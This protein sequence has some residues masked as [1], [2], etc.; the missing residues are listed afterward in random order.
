MILNSSL[1]LDILLFFQ[2]MSSSFFS[3]VRD[4]WPGNLATSEPRGGN[5]L[6]KEEP[7]IMRS[8]RGCHLFP[9]GSSAVLL[10]KSRP[11]FYHLLRDSVRGDGHMPQYRQRH[12][13]AV[14]SPETGAGGDDSDQ[15]HRGRDCCHGSRDL[16]AQ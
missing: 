6:P 8:D 5:Y 9:G 3:V 2:N 14:F 13:G 7:K 11:D 12:R 10:P 4:H 15:R 16:R 1:K